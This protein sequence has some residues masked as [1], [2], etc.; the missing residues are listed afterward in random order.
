MQDLREGVSQSRREIYNDLLDIWTETTASLV[1]WT[2][3][4]RCCLLNCI[5][6]SEYKPQGK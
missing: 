6:I 3:D 2:D 1:D 4:E 5:D